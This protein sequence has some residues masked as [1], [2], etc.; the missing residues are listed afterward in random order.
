MD[1]VSRQMNLKEDKWIGINMP[2][3]VPPHLQRVPVT[4]SPHLRQNPIMNEQYNQV[5]DK[6]FNK[7]LDRLNLLV[8]VT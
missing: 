6:Q 1:S 2:T 3:A 7:W 4:I 5:K 8:K